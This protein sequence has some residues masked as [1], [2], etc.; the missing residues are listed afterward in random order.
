V[1]LHVNLV[2]WEGLV[3]I[4]LECLEADGVAVLVLAIVVTMFLQTIVC[5][6]HIVILIV[7]GV[8]VTTCSQIP[9]LIIVELRL[10]RGE[11]PHPDV[12]LP[13]LE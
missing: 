13:P 5:K 10:M 4:L 6:V 12:E 9:L 7:K 1:L 3:Q 2:L 11:C 8:G